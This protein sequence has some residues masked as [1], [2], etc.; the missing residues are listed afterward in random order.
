MIVKKNL[1]ILFYHKKKKTRKADSKAPIYARLTIDGL[2]DEFIRKNVTKALYLADYTAKQ[3]YDNLT[4]NGYYSQIVSGN[5]SQ[6]IEMDSVFS[7]GLEQPDPNEQKV[8]DRL[9]KLYRSPK[10]N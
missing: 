6:R 7:P 5:I 8:N 9:A 4:E 1:S 2:D 10:S 3:E